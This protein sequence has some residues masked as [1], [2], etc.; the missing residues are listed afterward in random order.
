MREP[1]L[2]YIGHPLFSD[3]SDPAWADHDHNLAR[4]MHFVALFTNLGCAVSCWL[5]H[6][7][8][9]SMEMCKPAPDD[10]VHFYLSRDKA[11]LL[12]SDFFI[13][14]GPCRVSTGLAQERE[15]AEDAGMSIIHRAEWDE[16]DYWP[17]TDPDCLPPD[18]RLDIIHRI[19]TAATYNSR[20][21]VEASRQFLPSRERPFPTR[22]EQLAAFPDAVYFLG[23]VPPPG[24]HVTVHQVGGESWVGEVMGMVSGDSSSTGGIPK[25]WWSV[26]RPGHWQ[27]SSNGTCYM[28]DQPD[29]PQDKP[30]DLLFYPPELG[31]APVLSP[32]DF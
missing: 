7:V 4:Y 32:E 30:M 3:G 1:P 17:P 19:S 6:D 20:A 21:L 27:R 31:L 5:H 9:H 23:D 8:M 26:R 14:T 28:A 18:T 25:G 16:P 10:V 12:R 15:W 2:V 22:E 24:L 11:M 13:Q 29:T